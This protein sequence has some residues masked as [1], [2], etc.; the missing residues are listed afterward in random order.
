MLVL[1]KVVICN[2]KNKAV[3]EIRQKNDM[4]VSDLLS[5]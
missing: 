3:F 5:F 1:N 2:P 4:F